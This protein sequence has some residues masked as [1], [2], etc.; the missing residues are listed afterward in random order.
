MNR[1]EQRLELIE[2]AKSHF[3]DLIPYDDPQYT[4]KLQQWAEDYADTELS[5]NN[6]STNPEFE[7]Y[8]NQLCEE[9]DK[10]L[11]EINL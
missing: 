10:L 6:W 9:H 3:C 2:Y 7:K 8:M 5:G 4:E 11:D 1:E